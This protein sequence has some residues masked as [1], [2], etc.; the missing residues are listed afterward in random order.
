MAQ[1]ISYKGMFFPAIEEVSLTY[2]GDTD[3]PREKVS[4]YITFAGDVLR[5]GTPFIYKGPDRA[6]MSM[7]KDAGEEYLGKDFTRDVEFLEMVRK[8]NFNSVTEYLKFIGYDE[9]AE[10]KRFET[11]ATRVS[12]HELPDDS[13]EALILGGGQDKSG[14]PENDLVGGFGEPRERKK[15]EVVGK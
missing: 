1:F 6:A 2:D 8:F 13:P 5:K 15:T 7:L 4:K 3:I 12:R 14:K 9:A 10:K 11:L